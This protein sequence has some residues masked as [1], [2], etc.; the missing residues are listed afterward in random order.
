M[1]APLLLI[2]EDA[3]WLDRS[4]SHVLAFVGRRISL[5]H[6]LLLLAVRDGGEN[7][8]ETAGMDELPVLP[9]DDDSAGELLHAVAPD[10]PPAVRERLLDEAAGNPLALIELPTTLGSHRRNE[11][12][13]SD[14]LPLSGRLE[15]AFAARL[16]ELPL[17]TRTLL[18]AGAADGNASLAEVLS[19]TGIAEETSVGP[20]VLGPATSAGLVDVEGA[21]LRFRHPLMRSAAYQ[22]AT[23]AQRQSIHAA[24]SE[25]AAEPGRSV[26]HRAAATIG[27]DEDLARELE[28][29]AEAALRRGSVASAAAALERAA[30]LSGCAELTAGRL[31]R[32]AELAVGLGRLDVVG[33][34]LRE[35]EPLEMAPLEQGRAAWIRAMT[36]PGPPGEPSRMRSLLEVSSRMS[37][38]GDT[39]LALK[40]LYTAATS[41]FWADREN[42]LSEQIVHLAESLT[43][44]DDD[45]WL[46]AVL[47]YAAPIDRGEAVIERVRRTVPNPGEPDAMWLL[48]A[49]AATVGAFDLAEPYAAASVEGLREHGRLGAL[50]Q[51]LVL[52]AWSEIHIGRWDVALP[53][54]EE[55]ERL[56]QE[57]GQPIW[58]GGA[59]VAL[60]ILAGLRGD[61]DAAEALA[62]RAEQVGLQFGA[63][64]V[65]SV[66]QLARGLTALGAGRHEDAYVHLRRMFNP[67]DPA[68]HRMESCWAIGNLAEA[69]VHSG[70][71]DEARAVMEQVE[72]LTRRTP[73]PW[74]HVAMRHAR[75]LLAD[76]PEAEALFTVALDADLVRWPFDRARLLLAYGEWLRRHRRVAES[77]SP[78]RAARD[79]FD[80]LG[81]VSWG[82]RARHE[83]RAS[84]EASGAR[85]IAAW[86][87][88]TAQ[89]LQ[90]ARMAAEG[91]TNREIGQKLYLSHRTIGS[92]LYHT[93]RSWESTHARSCPRHSR[94]TRCQSTSCFV[95]TTSTL[96]AHTSDPLC[97]RKA[98][99]APRA[100]RP[101][102]R[103]CAICSPVAS[104]APSSIRVACACSS[105]TTVRTRTPPGPGAPCRVGRR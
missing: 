51:A 44:P 66:L 6:V 47:A 85:P 13:L 84:G 35:A 67:R 1:R 3:Q 72:L 15:R 19:A 5:E 104:M 79:S 39:G 63:R 27:V 16:R 9:L 4:T 73:S 42:E 7:P 97:A 60:S 101:R 100:P 48:S 29:V 21:Q 54:A 8:F 77:R 43:V 94:S 33:R 12:L 88:L 105:S 37:A 80:A 69:A 53:D 64:A 17:V 82:E 99:T 74:L 14:H 28:H 10:L 98:S 55:A 96:P 71:D 87:E 52:R 25:V 30:E 38:A 45:P 58:G 86:D 41:G 93:S 78:L 34:L 24:L 62:R 46:I 40:L 32:A 23:L 49:A 18:L 90:I 81:V 103:A 92:H 50:A 2:A 70:H 68:Y 36:V 22:T 65:L 75:A 76:D 11:T 20:D 31:L 26:W 91:M 61:Q 56:A 95:V 83:L 57:T 102:S 59:Q 89:E